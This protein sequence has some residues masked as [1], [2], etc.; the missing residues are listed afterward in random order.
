[1][2]WEKFTLLKSLIILKLKFFISKTFRWYEDVFAE[3]KIIGV[4]KSIIL[5]SS[6]V[7]IIT[8]IPIPFKSPTV[9]PTLIF[10]L[11]FMCFKWE[12][13]CQ[14]RNQK[15]NRSGTELRSH[16]FP[17]NISVYPYTTL[18]LPRTSLQIWVS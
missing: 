16:I 13:K 2:P 9:T 11:S 12:E 14:P 7:L 5:L 1:M 18:P 4:Q 8:S 3:E 6:K 10:F 15:T 17:C